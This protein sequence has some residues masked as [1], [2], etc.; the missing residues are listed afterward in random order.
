ME[1][2][3]VI[4]NYDKEFGGH[5]PGR[6]YNIGIRVTESVAYVDTKKMHDVDSF[7]WVRF[8]FDHTGTGLNWESIQIVPCFDQKETW[9]DEKCADLFKLGF[10]YCNGTFA[11]PRTWSAYWEQVARYDKTQWAEYMAA[12]NEAI[13]DTQKYSR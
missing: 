9:F 6:I 2:S 4:R 5:I 3:E 7:H 8:S 11:L 12:I 10:G 1:I 13:T